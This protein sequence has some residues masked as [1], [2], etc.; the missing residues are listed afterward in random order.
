MSNRD[1]STIY[2]RSFFAERVLVI[3]DG[4]GP[5]VTPGAPLAKEYKEENLE[6]LEA[7]LPNLQRHIESAA[8]FGV[9]VIVAVNQV[10]SLVPPASFFFFASSNSWLI[11]L[12]C[13]SRTIH[14]RR[15]RC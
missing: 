13:S 2:D 5:P 8:K 6:L 10:C 9:P 4:G 15:W 7:G 14:P 1:A 3:P 12:L 11:R